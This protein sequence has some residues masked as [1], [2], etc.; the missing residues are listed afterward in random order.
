MACSS[1]TPSK[2]AWGQEFKA[3]EG[4][5]KIDP[6]TSHTYLWPKIGEAQT[7]GQFKIIDQSKEWVAP[8]PYWAYPGQVCTP[9]GMVEKKS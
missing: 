2:A 6:E 8:D 1:S 3:P 4:L 7:S 9:T 5:V